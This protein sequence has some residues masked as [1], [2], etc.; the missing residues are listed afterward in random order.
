MSLIRSI[1]YRFLYPVPAT[2]R[3]NYTASDD[4]SVQDALKKHFYNPERLGQLTSYPAYSR[5]LREHV[6]ERLKSDRMNI[7]PWLN[8]AKPLKDAKVLEVGCGTGSATVALAEQGARVTGVDIDDGALKVAERR[9]A[10][11]GLKA[12]LRLANA[13]DVASA[14]EFDFVIYFATLEHMT[15]D[16][17]LE[18]LKSMWESLPRGGLLVIIETP[19][20]LW[21]HDHHTSHLDFWNWLPDELAYRYLRFCPREM[22]QNMPEYTPERLQTFLREGRGM[23]Y[24]EFELAIARVHKLEVVSSLSQFQGLRNAIRKPRRYRRYKAFLE[25]RLPNRSHSGW[26]EPFL[27]LIIRKP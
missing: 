6:S 11:H 9:L 27:N 25:S 1:A 24:H 10:V 15:I 5:D 16:E 3:A 2:Q 14:Q 19:N 8:A 18:S 12:D 17:R 23:S 26:C 13:T 20:R 7:I 21:F 22:Y 4:V